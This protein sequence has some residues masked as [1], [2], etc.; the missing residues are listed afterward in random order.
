MSKLDSESRI[1]SVSKERAA[2]L[3][4]QEA[5]VELVYKTSWRVCKT[6]VVHRAALV[7]VDG[8]QVTLK[9]TD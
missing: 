7:D 1:V 4:L 6:V 8:S 5:T 3:R 2:H 9:P